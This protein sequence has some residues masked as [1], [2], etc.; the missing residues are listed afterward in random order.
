MFIPNI[1]AHR[2]NSSEAPENT[3]AAFRS[4]AE[5]RSCF[6]EFDVHLTKD[7]VPV[8]FH[9]RHL[10]RTSDHA[11][12]RMIEELTLEEIK[13]L[14]C[15]KWF[16]PDFSGERILT[17]DE[18]FEASLGD[19]GLMLEIKEGSAPDLLLVTAVMTKVQEYQKKDK[20]RRILIGSLSANIVKLI[21]KYAPETE[22]I[23]ITKSQQ[24]LDEHLQNQAEFIA[25]HKTLLSESTVSVLKASGKRVWVWTVDL[26]EEIQRCLECNVDG[27][28]SNKPRIIRQFLILR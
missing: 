26:P 8:I 25:I 4:A 16:H 23:A 15:G 17:L 14:D 20:V 22:T 21:E 9:D 7:S 6:I 3:L 11:D 5:H 28:I 1:I 19:V 24:E 2:G 13:R 27:I 10:K 18:L 12:S